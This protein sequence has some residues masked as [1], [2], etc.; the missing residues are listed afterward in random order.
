MKL[1]LIDEH[2]LFRDAL[3]VFISLRFP[4]L[5]V[6]QAGEVSTARDHLAR[7]PDVQLVLLR[8]GLPGAQG[9]QAMT[10][11]LAQA[12]AARLVV[13]SADDSPD[14]AH[15]AIEA[16]ACSFVPRT[17]DGDTLTHAL[18]VTLDGGV[19]LPPG[20]WRPLHDPLLDPL[21]SWP[22]EGPADAL[23]HLGLTPRQLDVLQLLVQGQPTKLICRGLRLSE[24]TVKTHLAAVFRRLGV[25]SRTQALA[26]VSRLGLRFNG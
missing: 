2:P 25:H 21:A 15:Q 22:T 8:L 16:G 9:L 12:P 7:H 19:Y 13:L 1:L 20:I 14:T 18:Q 17:A 4:G 10:A 24:S 6:L 23:R 11:L 3:G 26:E 5:H